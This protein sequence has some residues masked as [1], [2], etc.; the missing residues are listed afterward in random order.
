MLFKMNSNGRQNGARFTTA[1]I[2]SV[3]AGLSGV[4]AAGAAQAH[5]F[6][7]QVGVAS[8]YMGKGAGKSAGDPSV[9]GSVE[10]S[11]GGFYANVFAST[12]KLSQGS[13]AEVISAVGWR[14]EAAG[15]KFDDNGMLSSETPISI[16]YLTND[17]TS[18]PA[19]KVLSWPPAA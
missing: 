4:L 8:Q 9:N 12:A 16:E 15:Y 18:P 13:D 17:G 7:A 2:G 1:I 10:W 3:V 19:G 14:P 6:D 5:A 11:G